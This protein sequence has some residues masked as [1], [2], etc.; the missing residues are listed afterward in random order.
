MEIYY[1]AGNEELLN[2]I[3]PLWEGLNAIH[4]AKSVHFKAHYAGFTFEARQNA[5]LKTASEGRLRVILAYDGERLIGY[6]VASV[7]DE[8]GEIDSIFVSE[9]FRGKGI[10]SRLME[11]ALDWLKA[12][13]AAKIALKV[14]VG[15][16]DVLG[17]YAKHGF[18]PR[19]LELQHVGADAPG[20]P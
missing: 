16:E 14:S 15:N 12:K 7:A 3:K 6:C 19:L 8:T 20:G 18:Y 1:I 4:Q 2:R 9:A 5:L 10:A 17:F 13:G 11:R